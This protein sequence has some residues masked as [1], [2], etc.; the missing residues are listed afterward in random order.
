MALLTIDGSF[1]E[2]G[3]QIVR[4]G[5]S[6]A[7]CTGQPIRISPIRP[8]RTKLGADLPESLKGHLTRS[9]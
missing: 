7:L 3:G 4:T 6:L 2:G 9:G 5:L 1:G 8:L